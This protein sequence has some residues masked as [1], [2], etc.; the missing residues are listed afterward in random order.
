M[1]PD[2]QTG[3]HRGAVVQREGIW[4]VMGEEA[5]KGWENAKHR[6][7]NLTEDLSTR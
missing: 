3:G 6:T 1:S 4:S 7:G 5:V 2:V